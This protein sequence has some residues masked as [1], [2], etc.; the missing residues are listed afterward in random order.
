MNTWIKL[1]WNK[2]TEQENEIYL[3]VNFKSMMNKGINYM[4]FADG[5]ICN[6]IETEFMLKGWE[7]VA[8]GIM[9]EYVQIEIKPKGGD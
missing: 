8:V 4:V 2:Y 5:S 1:V 7:I 9:S 3:K 6:W